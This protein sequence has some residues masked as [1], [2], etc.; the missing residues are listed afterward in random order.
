VTGRFNGIC[1]IFLG[2]RGAALEKVHQF[3]EL[4]PTGLRKKVSGSSNQR[5]NVAD[6]LVCCD[7]SAKGFSRV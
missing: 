4:K 2:F 1:C 3:L 7:L 6:R 5:V